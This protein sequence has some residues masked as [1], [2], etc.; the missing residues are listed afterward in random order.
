MRTF[1]VT[2]R[3]QVWKVTMRAAY[4]KTITNEKRLREII[5]RSMSTLYAGQS[6]ELWDACSLLGCITDKRRV[7][8]RGGKWVEIR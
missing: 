5:M 4:Q 7:E 3:G 8:L 1:R 2:E 6:I